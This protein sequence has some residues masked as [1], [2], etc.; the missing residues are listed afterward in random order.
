VDIVGEREIAERL[1]VPANTVHTWS[2]R[3]ILPQPEGTVSGMPAWEWPTIEN[4]ARSTGRLP[5]LRLAILSALA[6]GPRP[7][8]SI[9]SNLI[10]QGKA[11]SISQVWRQLNELMDVEHVVGRTMPDSWCITEQGRRALTSPPPHAGDPRIV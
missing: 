6:L 9:A 4:W 2:K 8:S 1:S 5:G 10:G 11:K 3:G 7:T